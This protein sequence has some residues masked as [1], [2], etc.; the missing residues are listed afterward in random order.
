[1]RTVK[2]WIA[3]YGGWIDSGV[4]GRPL[5]CT[6]VVRL[7]DSSIGAPAYVM[8]ADDVVL[9]WA[10]D[11]YREAIVVF[12]DGARNL[13][14]HCREWLAGNSVHGYANTLELTR[15]RTAVNV[16]NDL[17]H[18]AITKLEEEGH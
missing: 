4:R 9:L 10:Y 3:E 12:D 17:L 11:R 15:A 5:D 6:A 8:P 7:F 1:M 13:S 2:G 14:G 16:A 18:A